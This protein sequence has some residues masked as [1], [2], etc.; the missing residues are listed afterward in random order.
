[1]ISK[2]K[3]TAI[4]VIAASGIAWPSLI[5]LSY[6][7][8]FVPY[9]RAFALA[10]ASREMSAQEAATAGIITDIA[11]PGAALDRAIE[12]ARKIAAMDATY[13]ALLRK[14]VRHTAEASNPAAE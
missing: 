4:A 8:R 2:S 9:K 10:L 6:L 1:M 13:I 7:F 3:L 12:I 5:V 11:K 14:F